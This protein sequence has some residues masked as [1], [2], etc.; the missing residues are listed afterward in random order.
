MNQKI[1]LPD[2]AGSKMF[3]Q[4]QLSSL[5][6]K[7]ELFDKL[8]RWFLQALL[9]ITAVCIFVP[10]TPMMPKVDLDSS[11][12]FGVNY[13]VAHGMAFG[14][15][16]VFT[17]GPYAAIITKS[18]YPAI[19][20]LIVASSLYLGL[21]YG[22]ALTIATRN[23]KWYLLV[24]LWLVLSGLTYP[25]DALLYSYALLVGIIC[26]TVPRPNDRLS[27][28][29]M[30]A[31]FFPF[32]LLFLTKGSVI[33]LSGSV[34]ALAI[35]FFV[36]NK[37]WGQV[38]AVIASPIISL[39]FF[40]VIS[41]QSLWNLPSYFISMVPIVSG[42]SDAMS[43]IGIESEIPYYLIAAFVLLF[44]IT[45]E[46]AFA[47]KERAFIFC[48][49]F[50]Y[51]FLAFKGGFVRH[52]GHSIISA[53]S[54]LFAALFFASAFQSRW[55]SLILFLSVFAWMNIDSHYYKTSTESIP[56]NIEATYTASWDGLNNRLTQ[57]KWLENDFANTVQQ[58]RDNAKLRLLSGS[59][60]IYSFNQSDLIAS[61][62]KWNPRPT[63]Q[64]YSVYTPSLAQSNKEHLLGEKAPDNI[65]FR[66]SPIDGR[67]PSTED[68]AS[69]PTLLS[70]YQPTVLEND[71]LYLH[72]YDN[73]DRKEDAIIGRGSYTFGD[74]VPVPSAHPVFVEISI[75]QT[76]LGKL[77][78]LFYK[79]S[80]LQISVNFENGTTKTYRIV[81]GMVKTEFLISP[82]IDTTAEFGMLYADLDYLS[83]KK[84]KSFSISPESN[85]EQ[86]KNTYEVKFKKISLPSKMDISNLYTFN[87]VQEELA[88]RK[89]VVAKKCYGNVEVI[90][91]ISPGS[92]QFSASRLLITH[93]WMV[94]SDTQP[95]VPDS[96]LLALKDNHGKYIF[97]NTR[98]NPRPDVGAF[99]KNPMLNSS[100]FESMA[101]VSG[102]R[103]IYTLSLA[104]L[105]GDHIS[106]CP[107][108]NFP[109]SFKGA[110]THE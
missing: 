34:A 71:Y 69:W 70:H 1:I 110:A 82:L 68:G 78:G 2:S 21:S 49:F 22:F 24:A 94:A 109:G 39:V 52:D 73:V 61:G 32:G 56:R 63:F 90:N 53:A 65:I 54:V 101:D 80:H 18:Y 7:P 55:A 106:I 87:K 41:G 8:L 100:G 51:L 58:M 23:S 107:Q 86:W 27:I 30:V 79:P 98:K 84:V 50:V 17:F 35:G 13:A 99:L 91:G 46:V 62:N 64:S 96:I 47:V 66:V 10:F 102:I 83:D 11:W 5:K 36:T 38:I 104:F 26:F 95:N 9:L 72:K 25:V 57:D 19:D 15:D 105:E 89:V 6:H 48:V 40:W 75:K 81:S 3:K 33:I 37:R 76:A 88:K 31:L 97:I 103:G 16:I 85:E 45:R 29:L 43:T 108:F 4:V 59:T 92:A 60:D 77:A 44:A 42:Y 67:L 74:L 12:V 93:G 14:R 28:A 20:H